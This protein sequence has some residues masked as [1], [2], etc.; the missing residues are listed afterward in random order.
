MKLNVAAELKIPGRE[1]K[2]NLSEAMADMEYLSRRIRFAQPVTVEMSYVFDGTGFTVT[3]TVKTAFRSEC[4]RC[5]KEFEEPFAHSFQERYEK[6]APEDGEVYGYIGDE[7]DLSDL[8]RDVILLNMPGFSLCKEDC[9]GLCPV[10]GCD[11]NT[12]QCSC[13]G[14]PEEEKKNPFSGLKALLNDD[15][16]V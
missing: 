15:K 3:G 6:N 2:A 7:L 14:G 4:A 9:S 10:C 12:V 5:T 16:E 13:L 8:I 11:L 1:G